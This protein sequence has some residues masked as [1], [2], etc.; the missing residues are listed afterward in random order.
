MSRPAVVLLTAL[1]LLVPACGGGSPETTP[2]PSP[3]PSPS[4]FDP[5]Q[6]FD[7]NAGV[8]LPTAADG[9]DRPLPVA[10]HEGVAYVASADKLQAVDVKTGEILAAFTPSRPVFLLEGSAE[11]DFPPQAPIVMRSGRQTLAVAPFTVTIPSV[12]TLVTQYAVEIIAVDTAT[13]KEAWTIPV[14]LPKVAP[15]AP[16][17]NHAIRV[18]AVDDQTLV[19]AASSLDR[20]F[21]Y[22]V[23]VPTRTV[24]WLKEDYAADAIVGDAVIGHTTGGDKLNSI[25][26]YGLGDGRERWRRDG[27]VVAR[28]E[29]AGPRF[30]VLETSAEDKNVVTVAVIDSTGAAVT[31]IP[32]TQPGIQCSFDLTD[33][34]VCYRYDKDSAYAVGLDALSGKVLWQLP[35]QTTLRVAPRVSVAWHGLVYG[36]TEQSGPVVLEARTGED[37]NVSAGVSPF[38]VNERCGAAPDDKDR[39]FC[40][41]ATK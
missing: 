39:I 1:V 4:S 7:P 36:T 12:G 26:A 22:A 27:L 23:T 19:L 34:A 15:E 30:A 17:G 33:S 41:P 11:R 13:N 40:Y 20:S 31:P 28:A 18:V 3:S 21:S 25:V 14:E 9:V 6:Q 29:G 35:D 16:A 32:V 8:E 24:L 38:V 2:R 10:L 37:Q 5:P